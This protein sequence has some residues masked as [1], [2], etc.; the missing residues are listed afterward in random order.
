MYN[1]LEIVNTYKYQRSKRK[2]R[3][4]SKIKRS[5]LFAVYKLKKNTERLVLV[6]V[7]R[8]RAC[9]VC[10]QV[11]VPLLRPEILWRQL[12]EEWMPGKGS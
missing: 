11:T 4:I 9:A 8:D 2:A 5:V 1:G 6:I 3:R 7:Y 10:F 12:Y